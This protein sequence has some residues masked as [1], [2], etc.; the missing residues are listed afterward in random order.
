MDSK[1]AIIGLAL[2]ATIALP[3]L[4]RPKQGSPAHADDTVIVITPHNEAIRGEFA[5]GFADWYRA[6]TGRTVFIDWRVVG[7]TSDIVRYLGAEY[8]ASFRNLWEGRMHRPWSA[9]IQSGFQNG[10]LP[11]GVAPAVGQAREAF[12]KSDVGCGLDVFFGGG[13]YDYDKQAQAGTLVDSGLMARHPDWFTE[14]TFPTAFGGE[15]YRDPHG[16]W[17][18]AV[19]SSYGILYNRDAL[20]RLGFASEPGQ[21]DDLA[22]PR[23]L[24]QIAM[25]DP[26]KSGAIA[27]AFENVIQQQMRRRLAS[28]RAAHPS[29]EPR[30]LE[31]LAVREGWTDGLQLIQ[32]VGANARYFT[33]TSQKPAIDVGNGDCA[34][35][36]CIDF[37]GWEQQEAVK[38][39]GGSGRLGYV[40]PAGGSAYSVDPIA[41]LRGAPHRAV[42]AAFLEYVIS[43]DGQKLW[44]FRA[45]VPGGPRMYALRR[46]PVRKDFYSREDWKPLRTDP[47]IDPYVQAEPFAYRPEWTGALFREIGFITRVISQDTHSELVRAWRAIIA[48]PEPARSH[49]LAVLQD[50]SAVD[51]DHALGS[52]KRAMVSKNQV[53]ELTFARD[54]ANQFRRQ[55]GRAEVLASTR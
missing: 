19:V 15:Q 8:V 39:R 12:L 11:A 36:M 9:D 35:G 54:L 2:A 52:I 50:L 17:F 24:G 53:D 10:R 38:R 7:G 29:A 46:L 45:G 21:W 28:L 16:L 40:S 41:L 26:T 31:A 43:L 25:C 34:A 13:N 44:N 48:A 27:A 6:R 14:E 33:D 47:E 20:R 37:Y 30:E 49:A 51:Y 42:A 32:R 3:F 22:D 1:R 4:L 5:A 55:Y 23:F 18:G